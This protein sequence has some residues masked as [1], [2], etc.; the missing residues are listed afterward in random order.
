MHP[1]LFSSLIL[2]D[3]VIQLSEYDRVLGTSP[4]GMLNMVAYRRD[5]W[6]SREAATKA[7][8]K[9]PMLAS[10]DARVFR[11]MMQ[12]GLRDLPTALY[13]VDSGSSTSTTPATISAQTLPPE[14][15]VTLTST[16]HQEV[17]TLIRPNYN[18]RDPV[19][20]HIAIDRSTHADCDPLAAYIPLYRPEA[21]ATFHK[22]PF[23]RPSALFLLGSDTPV[24][25][26]EL[27]QGIRVAGTGVGGSGGMLEGRV[28]EFV[29]QK[30]GHL[31]CFEAVGETA[32]HCVAWL[33]KESQ[34]WRAEEEKWRKER[35]AR[36][37]K[38]DL[39][40]DEKFRSVVKPPAMPVRKPKTE[41]SNL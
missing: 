24:K 2:L 31:F 13:P 23:L 4:P 22:L 5:V 35:A 37:R 6:P 7:Y 10:W 29:L 17:W 18:N 3:P 12:Y 20:G 27:C 14:T 25:L 11:R 33:G 9:N 38:D 21:R 34:R 32:Q 16:K 41:A 26:N 30:R 8:A 19:T 15:P 1:R 39:M 28:E 40:I 36:T